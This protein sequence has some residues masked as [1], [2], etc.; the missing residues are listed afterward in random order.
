[1]D[2]RFLRAWITRQDWRVCGLRLQ[3]LCLGHLVNLEAIGSPLRPQADDIDL[4][5][6]PAD[7]LLAARICSEG[8]PHPGHLR[9]R[10]RDI[11]WRLLMERR[12][13][14]FRHHVS[15]F[16]AYYR[17]YTSFPEFWEDE[18]GCA[19]S[20]TAPAALSKAAFLISETSITE[21]RAWSMPLG[22]VDYTI[23]AIIERRT[24]DLR[25]LQEGDDEE[26]EQPEETLTE[27]QIVARAESDLPPA[28]F[29][30]WFEA[31]KKARRGDLETRRRGETRH[32]PPATRHSL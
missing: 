23:S 3:P 25:F 15:L 20:L 14:L 8:W 12:P 10:L 11:I 19:R 2:D 13:R 31:R 5:I 30:E 28:R 16:D 17:D 24:G 18:D 29:A 32:S 4:R 6:S 21:D 27:D 26:I 7:L 22:R 9:P 1:M